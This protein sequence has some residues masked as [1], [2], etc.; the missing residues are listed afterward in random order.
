M[1]S[2]AALLERV[3]V[4]L[5]AQSQGDLARPAEEEIARILTADELRALRTGPPELRRRP[6]MAAGL[7]AVGANDLAEG[8][9]LRAI[10][11]N[12]QPE[13]VLNRDLALTTDFRDVLG[14]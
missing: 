6:E 9:L 5:E 13:E 7:A 1:P 2:R 14:E 8:K 12:H 10:Y 3:V 4:R 11:G